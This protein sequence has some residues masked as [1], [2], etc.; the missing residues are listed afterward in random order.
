MNFIP[1][2]LLIIG[3]V[4]ILWY[5]ISIFYVAFGPSPPP[6][7]DTGFRQFMTI[8]IS[9]LSGT[10]ATFIGMIL[11]LQAVAG[12]EAVAAQALNQAA[13]LTNLQMAAAIA[14]VVSLVVA[15]FAWWKNGAK[16]D[17]TIVALAKSFL[18]LIGGV[19]AIGLNVLN[20]S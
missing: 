15:L 9:T 3:S 5:Y 4:A 12:Q 13:P 18:G 8:S 6:S 2:L 16:T 1:L 19:L 17:P 10:L 20:A 14:Y 7:G 11:G